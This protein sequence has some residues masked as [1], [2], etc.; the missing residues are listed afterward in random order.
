MNKMPQMQ[1]RAFTALS[2]VGWNTQHRCA[3]ASS[4]EVGM[5]A[6][7]LTVIALLSFYSL[8]SAATLP[9]LKD[10]PVA[11]VAHVLPKPEATRSERQYFEASADAVQQI[12]ATS[13]ALFS[14]EPRWTSVRY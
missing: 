9:P 4:T 14:A 8:A 10:E 11:R 6:A 3:V 5:K 12:R 13:A 2:Y 7:T 1:N